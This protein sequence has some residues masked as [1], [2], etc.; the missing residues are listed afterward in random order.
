MNI[1]REEPTAAGTYVTYT[2]DLEMY[3]PFAK[4]ILLLWIPNEGWYDLSSPPVRYTHKVHGHL[5]PLPRLLINERKPD[6]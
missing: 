5:G 1:S 4:R 3:V 2:N 6:E